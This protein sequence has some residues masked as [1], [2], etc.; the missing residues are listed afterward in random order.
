M[1]LLMNG[2]VILF[3]QE[4]HEYW[5]E[6]LARITGIPFK[7]LGDYE[8]AKIMTAEDQTDFTY[9]IDDKKYLASECYPEGHDT[10]YMI[11]D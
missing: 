8:V 11:V 2:S 4:G 1:P 10:I 3:P 9:L 5:K 7:S 6:A